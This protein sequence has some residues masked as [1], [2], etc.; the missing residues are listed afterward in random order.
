MKA[1]IRALAAVA[2]LAAALP[3]A[4]RA[5]GEPPNVILIVVDCL[6][7]DHLSLYGYGRKTSPNMD[8][9]AADAA[10]FRNATAQAPTTLLSF[11]SIFTSQEVSAHG[12]AD[13]T[14]ALGDSALTLAEIF[15]IYGYRTGAFT[16]GL[17][18]DPLFGLGRGFGTYFHVG[19]TDAS[20]KDTLPAALAWAAERKAKGEKFLLVAHG[21]DLHTPYVF[22]A[23]G[24][25]DNGGKVS[26][27]LKELPAG[28]AQLALLRGRKLKLSSGKGT[29]T[30][31]SADAA[32][33]TA[34]YDEGV[35]YADGLVGA[36]LDKLRAGGLL[37]NAVVV[38][39]ADHGEGLFDH[40]YYF[41]D[42]NMYE[43]TLHVPLIIKVPGAAHREITD[44][45]RLMDLMP[46][47][48]GLAGIPAPASAQGASLA[49]LLTGAGKGPDEPYVFSESS[50]GSAAVR[51]GKWKLIRLPAG[52]RLYDLEK[53]PGEKHDL[54]GGQKAKAAELLKIL[55]DRLAADAALASGGVLPAGKFAEDM[56]RDA[57]WER[58]VYKDAR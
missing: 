11:A 48:L 58:A 56:K 5:A 7:A 42:F 6:R 1:A 39:T 52:A 24:V 47:L 32:H 40:E 33:L 17:N 31:T 16:G 15:G 12:V 3:C 45:A 41:H 55:A 30:L 27:A 38:I 25:Y 9:F 57:A 28:E 36:F 26:R 23:S 53:D 51:A 46:T 35:L 20:F 54:A 49:P 2:A 4:S 50:V 22:P 44:Q 37:Q 14:H 21:N 10:V 18:L 8:S 19:R 13:Q 43:D 34:R 29:L